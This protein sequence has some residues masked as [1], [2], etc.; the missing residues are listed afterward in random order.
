MIP[1]ALLLLLPMGSAASPGGAPGTPAATTTYYVRPDGG[2]HEQ[3]T[4]RVNAPYPGSGT[5]Q[6]CAWDHPF[7]ALPPDGSPRISGGDTLIIA[8]AS[9]PMGLGAPGDDNC[10]ADYPWDCTMPPIPSGPDAAHPTR[11]LGG[12]WA[13]GCASPPE[14]WGRER[15]EHVLDL[16]DADHVEIACLEITDHSSCVEF[17][18]GGLACDRAVYPYGDW[19]DSGL[20]AQDSTDVH[21]TK[22]NIHGLASAGIRAGRLT[23]W[24][25]EDVRIRGN[26]W[27]GWEGDIDG[28][29]SN[30]GTLRFRDWTVEWNG[31]GETYPG[32]QPAGCWT[33]SAGG[34]GDGVGTG[35]TGGDWIIEDSQFL[36]NTSDGLDLL[37][38]SLGG[39]VTLN[40]VRAEG[41]AGNQ[42][43]ITGQATITNSVLVGNCGYFDGQ[44]FTLQVDPCRAY[45]NT[46]EVIYTGGEQVTIVNST[47]Y[48]Q[49]DGLVFAGPREDN[50]CNG[51]ETLTGR[52]NVFLGDDNYFSPG[53][54]TFL[55]YQENCEDLTFEGDYSVA[56]HVKNEAA[57][58]VDPPYP[59][60]HNLL[61]DPQLTGPFTG[62][63][64]G[65]VPTEGS[66][67]ID[68]GNDTV[69]PTVDIR[70]LPR[71][72]DGDGDGNAVCDMGAYEWRDLSTPAYL[73]MI[74]R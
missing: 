29:D 42:V 12:D 57:P 11:I 13:T 31:C 74:V 32:G 19:A 26:G 30:S 24:T 20:Y 35:A 56:Y 69:C 46:L 28:D 4:G 1:V 52:N 72:A 2:S 64:Y 55:F 68:G 50:S 15:A 59:S 71:P 70:G 41:N 62:S 8:S 36:H 61:Q 5:A 66:P 54:D 25:V 3:C 48:G 9:Y 18:T 63:T 58:W 47:F 27:V 43:K 7:R 67:A 17:H 21:L 10:D 33:E 49:G 45:G 14:L 6:P 65:L 38:H 37:Y 60:A 39:L 34:Y 73:P 23:D 22:L 16:T 44:P 51:T 53:D 40:R